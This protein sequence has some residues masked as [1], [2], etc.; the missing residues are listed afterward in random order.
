MRIEW[1]LTFHFCLGMVIWLIII[2]MNRQS[3]WCDQ[4]D[5][6]QAILGTANTETRACQQWL[7]WLT[8][9]RILLTQSKYGFFH[10]QIFANRRPSILPLKSEVFPDFGMRFLSRICTNFSVYLSRH[11]AAVWVRSSVN[12]QRWNLDSLALAAESTQL[13]RVFHGVCGTQF[14]QA[15][16]RLLRSTERNNSRQ[17]SATKEWLWQL[18]IQCNRESINRLLCFHNWSSESPWFQ[19]I[20]YHNR[21]SAHH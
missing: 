4:F 5:L 10:L 21:S 11:C 16:L 6:G 7:L 14:W 1:E 18:C 15:W 20:V 8:F 19:P 13:Q 2:F 17:K 12:R 3:L 9:V